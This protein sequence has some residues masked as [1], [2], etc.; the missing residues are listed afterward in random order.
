M[1]NYL[2]GSNTSFGNI[3]RVVRK[4]FTFFGIGMNVQWEKGVVLRLGRYVRDLGPGMFFA[5]PFLEEVYIVSIRTTPVDIPKQEIMTKDNVSVYVNSVVYFHVINPK[6]AIMNVYDPGYAVSRYAQTA[7]REV[8]GTMT[9]DQVLSER[10][11][12]ANR[13]EKIVDKMAHEWGID[14]E[15]IK[16]QDIVLPD[17]MK[18][19]MA[20]QAEAEREKRGLI[21]KASGE[22]ESAKNFTKAAINLEKSKGALYLRTLSTLT[23][24]SS[25]KLSKK[26]I[27]IIPPE[28]IEFVKSFGNKK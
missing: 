7:L 13:I 5:I 28:L 3:P 24:I 6:K 1:R 4:K 10:T 25:D 23:D 14:I 19:A 26:N 12:I 18:R 15:S 21:I 22:L 9:L 11:E 2:F 20:R 17:T 27:Y 8:I 16:I